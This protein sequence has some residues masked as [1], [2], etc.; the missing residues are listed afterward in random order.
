[1]THT[2]NSFDVF[3]TLIA[4]RSVHPHALLSQLDVR[5]G[6]SGLASARIA[7]DERLWNLGKPYLLSDIWSEVGRV[8]SLDDTT[9]AQL[10]TLE[11]EL[12][13]ENVIPIA[14]DLALVKDGDLLVSDT[15]LP[16]EVV[17]SLL[18]RAGLQRTVAL[19]T[20]NYGKSR[21]TIW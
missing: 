13:H 18:R 11:I 10:M 6:R 2:V 5:T 9:V 21:G 17:L 4:R 16:R 3:D 15:Y 8:L 1:M 20:S 19:V 14:Q 12:E 7:A